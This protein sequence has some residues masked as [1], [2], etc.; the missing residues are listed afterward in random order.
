[1]LLHK[2]YRLFCF[3]LFS[4]GLCILVSGCSAPRT[5]APQGNAHDINRER[6]IQ[7]DMIATK[8]KQDFKK[9]KS[10]YNRI[11]RIAFPLMVANA[12]FCGKDV[13]PLDGLTGWTLDM[14]PRNQQKKINQLYG[15]GLDVTIRNV[16]PGSPG[17]KAGI[18]SGDILISVN[19]VK[20]TNGKS[21][22]QMASKLISNAGVKP[23]QIHYMRQGKIRNTVLKPVLGC[24][25][26]VV[27]NPKDTSLNAY[28]DGNRIII[29]QGME[30]FTQNDTE[31]ALV[32]AHELAHNAMEHIGKK[33]TNALTGAL[34]GIALDILLSSA[35][36]STGNQ[37]SQLG[38]SLGA[39]AHSV[40][41]EQEADYVG[42]Y[43]MER[44]GYNTKNV[45][46]FWRRM[47]VENGE[48]SLYIR[49]TH[50]TSPERFVAIERTRQEILSKKKNG[51]PLYPN[52]KPK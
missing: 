27:I 7:Q 13:A 47:A 8:Q 5:A 10:D 2:K 1:M 41:F 21:G 29:S 35:G 42:M 26:P 36:V 37:I 34:G 14:Y 19:G 18:K 22:L 38:T 32:I 16:T 39:T 43:F 46:Y 12:Q 24:S 23:S 31:M 11:S 17:D 30:N 9:S 4:L 3:S 15:L 20:L 45:A 48:K 50:P 44:A 49:R 33:T 6:A 40:S 28:A 52:I 25:F 51:Q